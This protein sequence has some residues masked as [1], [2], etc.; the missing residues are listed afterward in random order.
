MTIPYQF[1]VPTEFQLPDGRVI[2]LKA[3]STA[4]LRAAEDKV[5]DDLRRQGYKVDLP[6]Y[7][8]EIPNLAP[9]VEV[10]PVPY[11]DTTILDAPE[12]VKKEYFECKG[13]LQQVPQLTA[14]Q[15]LSTLILRG[16]EF[17][18]PNDGW[19]ER[20]ERDGLKVP[21]DPEEK[22]VHYM[23]TEVLIPPSV[24]EACAIAIM[25]LSLEGVDPEVINAFESSFQHKIPGNK[26]KNTGGGSERVR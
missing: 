11:D 19:E 7:I 16:T 3:V 1:T 5:K 25:R 10:K 14:G 12:E 8:P 22:Y 13:V 4:R 9:G 17:E 23:L 24:A 15:M 2:K 21:S 20:Q 6:T 26:R 18:I